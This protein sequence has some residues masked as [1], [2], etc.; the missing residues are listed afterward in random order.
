ML[1]QS[2]TPPAPVPIYMWTSYCSLSWPT[3]Y[4]LNMSILCHLQFPANQLHA[5]KFTHVQLVKHHCTLKH[6]LTELVIHNQVV[7]RVE[8]NLYLSAHIPRSWCN[9]LILDELAY[10]WSR[11]EAT[12][13]ECCPVRLRDFRHS[14]QDRQ[15]ASLQ[16][17]LKHRENLHTAQD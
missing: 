15:V 3:L 5:S 17:R 8:P 10:P 4:V 2:S 7:R 6:L 14:L 1:E 9:V 13:R 16:L 12:D 11:P